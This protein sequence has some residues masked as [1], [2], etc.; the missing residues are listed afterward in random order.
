MST[1]SVIITHCAFILD[2][3]SLTPHPKLFLRVESSGVE[4]RNS[5]MRKADSRRASENV[6]CNY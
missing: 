5:L 4:G 6:G 2:S 3:P 1:F